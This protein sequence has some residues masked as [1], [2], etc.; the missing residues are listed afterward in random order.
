MAV[1]AADLNDEEVLA[2]ASEQPVDRLVELLAAYERLGKKQVSRQLADEILKKDPTNAQAMRVKEGKPLTGIE[3]PAVGGAPTEQDIFDAKLDGLRARG[4]YG[5]MASELAARKRSQGG[6][7]F[8]YQEDL[9]DAYLQSGNRSAAKSAYREM[10]GSGYPSSQRSLARKAL[11]EIEEDELLEGATAALR[12]RDTERAMKLVE[13]LLAKKPG[14]PDALVMKAIVLSEGGDPDAALAI[15]HDLKSKAKGRFPYEVDLAGIHLAAKHYDEAEEIY[16]RIGGAAGAGGLKEVQKARSIEAA[17]EAIRRGRGEGALAIADEL[18]AAWP[19]DPDI[20]TLRGSALLAAGRHGEAAAELAAVKEKHY[21]NGGFPAQG[22]LA[23]ALVKSNALEEAAVAYAEVLDGHYGPAD[24]EDA[25]I[26]LREIRRE[27]GA[28]FA[29][30]LQAIS[31]DEGD[32]IRATVYG[33]TRLH[34]GW[35]A[36]GWGHVDSIDLAPGGAFNIDSDE[37][38]EGGIALEHR[39]DLWNTAFRVGGTEDD[40]LLGARL[41]RNHRL[42]T[43]Y[44]EGAYNERADDSVSLELLDGRQHRIELGFE[45]QLSPR[46]Y[47]DTVLY[48]RQVELFDDEIGNGW[49]WIANLD[50][51]VVEAKGRRPALRVG[52]AG[53]VHVF[54]AGSL[55]RGIDPYL[56]GPLTAA[57]RAELLDN[58]VEPEINLHG[59]RVYVDGRLSENLA[60]YVTGAL[61]YDFYDKEVQYS[62]GAGLEAFFSDNV[63]L[64]LGLDYYSAGQGASG[65]SGVIVGNAGVSIAF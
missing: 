38:Y 41:G 22:D 4:A 62:A 18:A 8:S 63:R 60:W 37:R 24:R 5:Q 40:L 21:P 56:A 36:W 50:Y 10:A 12:D 20:A 11:A 55:G 54:D 47:L 19:K 23:M 39:G 13:E 48:A 65:D 2:K 58:L 45:A 64:V 17:Y 29:T 27:L 33:H 16:H 61:Q 28:E 1:E 25:V 14:D 46:L 42:G 30:A 3:D 9:A 31:E 59:A 49:G 7:V 53:E 26:Q 52:Y 44:L 57:E 6:G 51:T 34:D 32:I 35:R 15:M 43:W